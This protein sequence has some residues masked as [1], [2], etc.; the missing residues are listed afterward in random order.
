MDRAEREARK[1]AEQKRIAA[2]NAENSR[3]GF[4]CLSATWDGSHRDL[5]AQLKRNLN[6]PDSFE[7]VETRVTPVNPNGEHTL[8][9]EFRARNAFG[10]LVLQKMTATYRNSDC[11]VVSWNL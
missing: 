3:K 11:G 4:H 5:V 2:E 7:H 6:D 9:M 8:I 1:E 10:A